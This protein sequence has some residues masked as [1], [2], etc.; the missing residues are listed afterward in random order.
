[1]GS[2]RQRNSDSNNCAAVQLNDVEEEG[3]GILISQS[4]CI[5]GVERVM[6]CGA[7]SDAVGGKQLAQMKEFDTGK[8]LGSTLFIDDDAVGSRAA[9]QISQTALVPREYTTV[10]EWLPRICD[11]LK[12]VAEIL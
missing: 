8:C 9:G 6:G 4:W 10:G 5:S 3:R 1:M 7:I 12:I 2:T 11:V